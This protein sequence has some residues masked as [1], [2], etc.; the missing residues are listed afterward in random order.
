MASETLEYLQVACPECLTPNRVPAGR[1]AEAPKC[2]KCGAALLD[3]HPV[4]LTEEKFD[5]FIART[6]MPVLVDFWAPWC[7]P[8]R[9]MAPAFEKAAADMRERLRFAKLN[10]DEAQTVAARANIRAIPTMVLYRAG[11]EL[12]RVSGAMDAGSLKRWLGQHL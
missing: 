3:A 12:A 8:C 2:G 10:T 7:G 11:K 9:A 6:E 5:A 4:V 1:L